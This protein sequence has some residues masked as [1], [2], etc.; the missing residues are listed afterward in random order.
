MLIVSVNQCSFLC[1]LF[2]ILVNIDIKLD[3]KQLVLLWS[4]K[5]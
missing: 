3:V 2:F 5:R 4:L 1:D